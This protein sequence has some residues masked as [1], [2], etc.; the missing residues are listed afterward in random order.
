[1]VIEANIFPVMTKRRATFRTPFLIVIFVLVSACS[2]WGQAKP[3]DIRK[4]GDRLLLHFE[5]GILDSPM[6][7]IRHGM[8]GIH[9]NWQRRDDRQAPVRI[10][11]RC[12]RPR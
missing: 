7:H 12:R 10:R 4:D 9:V 5:E 1:M 2:L 6:F 8:D 3:W 11:H